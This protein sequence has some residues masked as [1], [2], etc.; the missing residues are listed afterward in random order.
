[1]EIQY[2]TAICNIAAAGFTLVFR[3]DNTRAFIRRFGFN[4]YFACGRE[5]G[6]GRSDYKTS[7]GNIIMLGKLSLTG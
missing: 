4:V 1:M 2:T 3:E 5:V 7:V 6:V